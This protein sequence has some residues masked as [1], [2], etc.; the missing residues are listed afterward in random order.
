MA[1]IYR[2]IR[3]EKKISSKCHLAFPYF[4]WRIYVTEMEFSQAKDSLNFTFSSVLLHHFAPNN[5]I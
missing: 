5:K 1:L 2:R 4:I 3:R